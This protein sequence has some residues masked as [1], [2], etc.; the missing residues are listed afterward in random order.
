MSCNLGSINFNA[1]VRKPFT[2][3]AFFDLDR[4][5]EVVAEMVRGLD[6]LLDILGER[7]AL[8]AQREHVKLWREIGLGVM[9]LADLALSMGFGYGTKDF[10]RVLDTIMHEMANSA[11]QASALL[12]KEKGTFPKYDYKKISQSRFFKEVYT[13][14]TKALIKKYGLRNSRL[15]SIAPTGS[16]SNILGVSGGVEPF[17]LLGYQRII[18]SMFEKERA[19][20]VYEKTPQRL[21]KHLGVNHLD[22]LPE[23][24]KVTSQNIKF[25]D[26]A[27]VQAIIQKYVDTAISSTFNLPNEAT[28]EDIENIYY[29][30]WKLGF[31][32]VTVFRDNCAKIGIL[33][34]GGA[35]FD[36]NPA[37]KPIITVEEEWYDKTTNKTETF[38]NH[39]QIG[40]TNY[41]S[42]KIKKE[43]CPECGTHL[44]RKNGCTECANPDCDYEKCAI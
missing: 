1:F 28:T 2:D 6:L 11:A 7:H 9:G 29:Q 43:L 41:I 21:M 39:I 10:N 36:K 33:S 19:I 34:N 12:A 15:L 22:D 40:D 44:V 26:R 8:P 5:K 3:D 18:K 38:I 20:W 42:E 14:E 23:W 37:T 17:F 25:E 16:I 30:A 32:G 31:K 24:A 4:F 27:K 13:D 35:N